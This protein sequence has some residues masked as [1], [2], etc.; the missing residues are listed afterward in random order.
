M[1]DASSETL[2]VY[3]DADEEVFFG[4]VTQREREIRKLLPRRT[5]LPA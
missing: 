1:L 4:P 2:D 3:L 5:L